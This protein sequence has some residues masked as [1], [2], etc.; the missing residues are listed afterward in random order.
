MLKI[1]PRWCNPYWKSNLL[2]WGQK[3]ACHI[4]AIGCVFF[5]FYCSEQP[6][7][8]EQLC[9][10]HQPSV[11]ASA[12]APVPFS[13]SLESLSPACSPA[14]RQNLKPPAALFYIAASGSVHYRI[15]V[16]RCSLC[17]MRVIHCN[18]KAYWN[19]ILT[20][21]MSLFI[22]FCCMTFSC[23]WWILVPPR[24]YTARVLQFCEIASV[25]YW[26]GYLFPSIS[27]SDA[28]VRTTGTDHSE[29]KF[30]NGKSIPK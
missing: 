21:L 10:C 7:A 15:R 25:Q 4:K 28:P 23:D 18:T 27:A 29:D 14:C 26:P 22:M 5:F 12:T 16:C 3:K 2:I 1:N 9:M 24:F 30:K 19:T 6:S 8:P 20:L 13:S 17:G 11:S